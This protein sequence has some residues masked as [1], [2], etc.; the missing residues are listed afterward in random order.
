MQP[1]G[2]CLLFDFDTERV[3]MVRQVLIIGQTRFKQLLQDFYVCDHFEKLYI[4]KG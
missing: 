3:K 1:P 2:I 4:K